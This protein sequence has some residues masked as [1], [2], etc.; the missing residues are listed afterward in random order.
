MA[1]KRVYDPATKTWKQVVVKDTKTKAKPKDSGS[2]NDKSGLGYSKFSKPSSNKTIFVKASDQ[3][4][5]EKVNKPKI[6]RH[7]PKKKTFPKKKSYPSRYRSKFEPT[8]FYCGIKGH[9]PNACYVRN[10]SVASGHYVWVKK[11]TNY[12][13]PKA[14]WVPNKT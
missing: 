14:T 11:G 10:F 12:E 4:S 6:V 13:G 9:T 3:S 1:T 8:C 5:K 2:S 7:Y